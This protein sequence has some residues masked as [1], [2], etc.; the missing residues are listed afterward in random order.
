MSFSNIMKDGN[1]SNPLPVVVESLFDIILS[2]PEAGIN[3]SRGSPVVEQSLIVE[4]SVQPQD[5]A[6]LLQRASIAS[7]NSAIS[8]INYVIKVCVEVL[9]F[10]FICNGSIAIDHE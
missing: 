9:F 5:E 1:G 2:Q 6:A 10:L 8:Y 3:D 4:G 7:V